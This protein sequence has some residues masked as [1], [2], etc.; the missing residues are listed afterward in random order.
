VKKTVQLAETPKEWDAQSLYDKASLYADRMSVADEE[1]GENVLWS[2]LA[3]ELLAR[4]A[5]ANVSPVL[6]VDTRREGNLEHALGLPVKVSR[7]KPYSIGIEQVLERLNK[8]LPDFIEEHKEF[9]ISHIGHRNA[10]LHSGDSPYDRLKNWEGAYYQ[11]IE[12]L[13]KSIG[14]QLEDLIGDED[15]KTARKQV[16]AYADK[17]AQAVQKDVEASK[18][19]W[20]ALGDDERATKKGE[21]DA[22]ATRYH[23]HRIKCPACGSTALV[24]GEAVGSPERKIED[25]VIT[26]TQTMLPRKFECIACGLKINGLAKL[27]VVDLGEKYKN[28]Q[29]FDAYEIFSEN[30][31]PYAGYEDDN[32]ERF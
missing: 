11:A 16:A 12:V 32:N 24:F 8:V 2:A 23:G 18:A 15:A 30:P 26:E 6:L 7:F 27:N 14:F 22:W 31:D 9:C 10:E 28:T 19:A 3:L 17:G 13:L 1:D 21:A 4:A 25:D 20:G 5:L 29:I